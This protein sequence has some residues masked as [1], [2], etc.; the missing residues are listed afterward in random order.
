MQKTKLKKGLSTFEEDC[1]WM[2][3]RY[4][5]GRSTI[6]AHM[7]ADH[8]AKFIYDKL[9]P[10]RLE[11]MSEDI[12]REIYDKLK[13]NNIIDFGWYGNIPKEYFK[14]INV[15]YKILKDE[16][17]DS[18]DKLRE[19]KNIRIEWDNKVQE[20]IHEISWINH[21]SKIKDYGSVSLSTFHDLEIWQNLANLLDIR[22][23]KFCRL[24]DNTV[25]EYYEC[26]RNC[27]NDGKL[28]F[29]KIKVPIECKS[30][31]SVCCYIPEENIIEDNINPNN[32]SK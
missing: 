18:L 11:F 24:I 23:H 22:T 6:A 10:E 1:I 20:Y 13:W 25:V 28:C 15:V 12:C 31:L 21:D 16:N 3:Y 29:D 32:A 30:N 17:I 8:I 9:T 14:P 5:I 2:S 19:I 27:Y 26:W 7:H 4:C